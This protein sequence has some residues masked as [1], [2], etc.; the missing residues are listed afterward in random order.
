MRRLLP[1]AAAL[2]VIAALVWAF[3]PRPVEVDLAEIAA[4]P[5]EVAVEDGESRHGVE[6][7]RVLDKRRARCYYADHER[8]SFG[9]VF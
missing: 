5:L 9:F 8:S 2:A 3:L 4:R 6:L 7:A 1:L